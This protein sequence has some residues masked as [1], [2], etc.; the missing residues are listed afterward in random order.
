MD[1]LYTV[2]DLRIFVWWPGPATMAGSRVQLLVANT[3][4]F[5]SILKKVLNFFVAKSGYKQPKAGCPSKFQVAWGY[6]ATTKSYTVYIGT[7]HSMPSTFFSSLCYLFRKY[8]CN[9]EFISLLS[10][11]EILLFSRMIK[12]IVCSAKWTQCFKRIEIGTLIVQAFKNN[13]R[14]F[15]GDFL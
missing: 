12:S 3:G 7:K 5:T 9:F 10:S 2:Y 1:W 13:E 14:K 8:E 6:R 4:I 15:L 11:T